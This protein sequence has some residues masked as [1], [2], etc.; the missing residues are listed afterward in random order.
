[1]AIVLG[2]DTITGIAAGGLPS[3]I[4]THSEIGY[5]G[6]IVQ[7]VTTLTR[8]QTTYSAPISGNG[9][10]ID[11]VAMTI[12]PRK[13]GNK[14]ILKWMLGGE[15]TDNNIVYTITRNDVIMADASNAANNRWAGLGHNQY[16]ANYSSTPQPDPILFVD[17][18]CLGVATTYKI[19]VRSS[20][21]TARTYYLNRAVANPADN[22]ETGVSSGVLYE[23]HV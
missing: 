13:A 8:T 4:I 12:T 6:C 22:N 21:G 3:G 18:A 14:I 19:C 2:S 10:S 7:T 9:T 15:A 16:D 5:P 1:M 11:A 23:V 20:N 17:D